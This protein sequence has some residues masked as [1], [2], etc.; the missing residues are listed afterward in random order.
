MDS[1][2]ITQQNR[3]VP[4][5]FLSNVYN[6]LNQDMYSIGV[7]LDFSKAFDCIEH[8]ILYKKL[9][10]I[11]IRGKILLLSQDYL[12][13]RHQR[14]FY[15]GKYSNDKVLKYGVPQGSIL[16]PL[17]FCIYI[18]D[19]INASKILSL[20]LFADDKNAS[21]SHRNP[22]ALVQNLNIELNL[23]YKWVIANYLSLNM[24]KTVY[25][26]FAK[27]SFIGPLMPVEIGSSSL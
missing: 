4:I 3:H 15:N 14:V 5:S 19:V 27:N 26:L 23:V 24:L 22:N 9:E 25:I 21:M 10:N 7:F 8:K 16:G 18:N 17:L 20:T 1:G 12:T 13:E 6:A 11:G 2:R